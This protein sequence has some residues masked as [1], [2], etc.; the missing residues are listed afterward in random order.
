MLKSVDP[1]LNGDLLKI[2]ADMGHGDTLAVVDRNY[3][4]HRYGVP[5]VRLDGVSLAPVLRSIL[6]V[7]PL[8]SF[9]ESPVERMEID[10][11]PDALSPVH[12]AAAE[13]ASHAE[14]RKVSV[15]SVARSVFYERVSSVAAIVHTGEEVGYSCFILRKGVV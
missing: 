8:D 11:K 13:E 9:V 6:T 2:L 4:S 10:G 3:P 15:A 14:G 1:L 12:R 5:V 7:F